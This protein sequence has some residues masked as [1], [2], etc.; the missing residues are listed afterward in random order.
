[1]NNDD[2]QRV[3][4]HFSEHEYAKEML[5]FK[6]EKVLSHK[7]KYSHLAILASGQAQVTIDSSTIIYTAPACITIAAGVTHEI[8]ALEN[9]TWYCIHATTERDPDK[10]DKTVIGV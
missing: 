3:K 1:M 6:G 10:I 4:H 9:V 7:H 8:M 2:K 5:L